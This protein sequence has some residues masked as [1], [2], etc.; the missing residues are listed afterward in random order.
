[1]KESQ[2]YKNANRFRLGYKAAKTRAE[3]RAIKEHII[4]LIESNQ[5]ISN[6]NKFK[7]T[8]KK[9]IKTIQ[10]K[11]DADFLNESN[12]NQ[13]IDFINRISNHFG[14]FYYDTEKYLNVFNDKVLIGGQSINAVVKEFI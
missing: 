9:T 12:F 10:E 3:K 11:Y 13:Y 2:F 1:M 4:S 8:V 6:V 5:N 14:D 7:R